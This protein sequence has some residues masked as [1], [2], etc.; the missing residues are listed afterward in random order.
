MRIGIIG[1]GNVAQALGGQ[2]ARA[3]HEVV[4]GGLAAARLLEATTAF[5]LGLW[6]AGRD[7]QAVFPPLV[8]AGGRD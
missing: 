8:H 3:G 1:A 7:A 2:W 5:V 6:F 4:F